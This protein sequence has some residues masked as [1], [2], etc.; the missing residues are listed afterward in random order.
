[1]TTDEQIKCF[2]STIESMDTEWSE[3]SSSDKMY[4]KCIMSD[5]QEM[6]LNKQD[7]LARQCLNKAK[8]FM[9]KFS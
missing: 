5:V 1:M 4:I 7:E 2:G 9:D 6:I 8:Y 3:K